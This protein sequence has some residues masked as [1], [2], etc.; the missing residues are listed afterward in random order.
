MMRWWDGGDEGDGQWEMTGMM[1]V[2][3]MMR[4][5]GMT[6]TMET[7]EMDNGDDGE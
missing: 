3:G 1:R 6:H 5:T 4:M 7:M 2:T